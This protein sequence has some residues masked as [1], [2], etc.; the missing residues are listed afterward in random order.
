M[1]SE[2]SFRAKRLLEQAETLEKLGNVI[3]KNA[4]TEEQR[5]HAKVA[6][7]ISEVARMLAEYVEK[8]RQKKKVS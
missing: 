1:V 7:D 3:Q 5:L 4:K 8:K 6:L 2:L